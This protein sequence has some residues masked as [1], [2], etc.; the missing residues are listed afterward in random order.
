MIKKNLLI[1]FSLI[2]FCHAIFAQDVFRVT[3]LN[4]DKSNFLLFLNSPDNTGE[5]I[6]KDVKLVKLENPKRLYLD[7][8]SAVLIASRQDWNLDNGGITQI[9]VSQFS[10]NPNKIRIVFYLK[11]DFNQVKISFLKGKNNI[12]IKLNNSKPIE[13]NFKNT[14]K[15][16]KS[17]SNDFYKNLS[18]STNEVNKIKAVENKSSDENIFNTIQQSFSASVSS[19]SNEKA[20]ISS[21]NKNSKLQPKYYISFASAIK[22]G[23]LIKGMGSAGV[24]KPMYLTNPKRAVFDLPNTILSQDLKNKEFKLNQDVIKIGQFEPNKAR[25]VIISEETEKYFPIFSSDGQSVVFV[26]SENFDFSSL[27]TKTTDAISYEV[28]KINSLTEEFII[29]FSNPVVHS[30]KRDNS[31]IIL[32]FYN[33]LRYNDEIFKNTIKDSNLKDMK[34]D[35]MPKVGLKLALSL[36]KNSVVKCYLGADGKSI[37]LVAT[38][39]KS[40]KNTPAVISSDGIKSVVI[41]AGHGGSDYGAIKAGINEKDINLDIAKRVQAIL[42]SKKVVVYMERDK[43]ETVSL[44]DRV[45]FCEEKSPI[46]FVSIHVNSSVKPEIFGIETHYY[47]QESLGL[48]QTVHEKLISHVPSK[49]RGLFKSKFYV[50]NHT[51]VPAILVEI[52]FLSNDT[53]RAQLVSEYRKQQTA[54]AIAEGILKYLDKR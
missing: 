34:I 42:M 45:Q 28:K 5:E 7:I 9:K 30:I 8:N 13:K 18:I 44:K 19:V 53:E 12:V 3:S 38:G 31:S 54:E 49:D 25:I 43:D 20:N 10:T 6:M 51:K 33:A 22:N 1:I 32:N 40:N 2:F 35:L 29:L 37:K 16:E 26:N 41:D 27:Y 47:H 4:L 48:A 24:E 46:V 23:F 39:V 36:E 14:Y 15:D 11:E 50:I 17:S 21:V 52:G